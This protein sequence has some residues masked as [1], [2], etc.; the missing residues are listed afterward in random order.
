M[1]S[2]VAFLLP[3]ILALT[4]AV[5]A[6]PQPPASAQ[7]CLACHGVK[8]SGAPFVDPAA[9]A[10][11]PHG[12]SDCRSCHADIKDFPHPDKVRGVDCGSCHRLE[13]ALVSHGPHAAGGCVS[14]HGNHAMLWPRKAGALLCARC[15]KVEVGDYSRSVH[16]RARAKGET[17]AAICVSCHG[18]AH[19]ISRVSNPN[20]PVSGKRLAKTCA[21]CHSNPALARRHDLSP[22]DIY[23]AYMGSTHAGAAKDGLPAA[24]CADCHGHHDI[25]A[26]GD[27]AS[28]VSAA[29]LVKTCGRCHAFEARQYADSVHGRA[30][31]RG[32]RAAPTCVDCHGE[33]DIR[34]PNAPGSRV[35]RAARAETCAGCHQSQRLAGRFGLPSD[36]VATYRSSFHGLANREGDLQVADCASCHGWHDVLASSNPRSRTN[37]ARLAETCGR[38]HPGAGARWSGGVSVHRMLAEGGSGSRLATLVRRLYLIVI[39]FTVLFMLL[40]NGLDLSR[41]LRLQRGRR[42]RLAEIPPSVAERWQHAA[43]AAA[44]LMLAYSGFALH[45]PQAWWAAP[46]QT[47]GGELARRQAHRAAAALFLLTAAAHLAYL[48]TK[49]GRSRLKALLPARRDPGDLLKMLAYNGRRS[50]EKPALPQFSYIEKFEYWALLWGSLVM[51][52]TGALLFFH[53]AALAALP[54]WS[55]A[56]ARVAHYYEA[57]LA[58]LAILIWHG[59]WVIF[60]PEVYPMDWA[61]LTGKTYRA[62]EDEPEQGP[63]QGKDT[64]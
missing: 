30:V 63:K 39:P 41:K 37:P 43:N 50:E 6:S 29:R 2:A 20:S 52:A 48:S 17:D 53:N 32:V 23:R 7:A 9:F 5:S 1:A 56:V 10:A 45:S 36:R 12:R 25:R 34:A 26:P 13:R 61:W 19:A 47:L 59:Y 54:L 4:A 60:D 15:H 42:R 35:S 28:S 51:T 27:P 62:E 46:F 8:D 21:R 3:A 33:H 38:C 16:G 55:V 40:H 64:K 31:A 22:T 14:C 49:P 44:F 57:V 58:C 11:S 24:D 18:Q